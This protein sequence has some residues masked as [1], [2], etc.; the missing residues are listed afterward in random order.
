MENHKLGC[1][2]SVEFLVFGDYAMFSDPCTRVGGEKSSMH[3][4]T[5]EALKGIAESIYWKPTILWV[6]DEVRI[7]KKIRTETKAV[8]PLKDNLKY[9]LSYYTYLKDVAYQVR[10]HFIWHPGHE[11]LSLDRNE[12][13]HAAM[14]RRMIKRGGR[15]DMF[16]GTRECQGY[17]EPCRFGE[18]KSDYDDQ[19]EVSYG[20]TYHGITYPDEAVLE[21]DKGYMTVRFWY[22][23]LLPGGFIKFLKPEECPS[24]RHIKRGKYESFKP[25]INFSGLGEFS[26]ENC[27]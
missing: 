6:I 4:P 19:P 15:R 22:P 12:N 25:G 9:D 17:V 21:E 14:A 20:F 18:G 27:L 24:A 3:L 23:K 16:L 8:T 13:K 2:N 26:E 11:E 10:A 1:N 7:M 5:Y